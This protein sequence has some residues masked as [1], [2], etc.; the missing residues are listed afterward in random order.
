MAVFKVH[1]PVDV[2]FKKRQGGGRRL[3]FKEFWGKDSK[4]SYLAGKCGCYVFA[5]QTPRGLMPLYVGLARKNFRQEAFNPTNR[6]KYNDGFADYARGTP[7]MFFVVHP[8]QR[9]RTNEKQILEI[10]DVLI[11]WAVARN[12]NLQNV[13][14]AQ[15]PAWSIQGVIRG[16]KGKPSKAETEFRK[17]FALK[18]QGT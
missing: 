15:T 3:A 4:A 18:K 10:E 13:K 11:Q 6:D 9:G 1:G 17:L 2:P 14:G 5:I 12:P 7:V 16:G 8:P